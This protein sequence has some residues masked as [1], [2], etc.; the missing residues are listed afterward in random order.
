MIISTR[1]LVEYIL[2]K[3]S[4]VFDYYDKTGY[5]IRMFEF[6]YKNLVNTF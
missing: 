3:S 1:R 6:D 5:L 4:R 2:V